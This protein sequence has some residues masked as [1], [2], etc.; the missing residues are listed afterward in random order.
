MA[1]R[2]QTPSGILATIDENILYEKQLVAVDASETLTYSIHAGA[3]PSGLNLTTTGK[4]TG[5]PNEVS[6]RTEK[7]FVV[8]ATSNARIAD[9][10]FTLFVE[11]SDAPTWVTDAGTL[12]IVYDGQFV[13]I[14]LQA[15]D[16]D[17]ADSSAINYEI[18][19]G[20]LPDSL[21]LDA[22]TGKI[23]GVIDSI[24]DESF[25]SAQLGF[26]AVAFDE[27][28]PFDLVLSRGSIDR[29]FEFTVRVT[30]GITHTDRKF[31]L[32]VRGI[33]Q[34]STDNSVLTADT[35]TV[36]ADQSDRTAVYFTQ[37]GVI[38]TLKS[39][40]YHIVKLSTI[41]PDAAG[42]LDGDTTVTYTIIAG[43]LPPG[44]S[45]DPETGTISGIVPLSLTSFTDYTFTVRASKV[46]TIFADVTTDQELIIRVTGN[47][48]ETLTW[49]VPQKEL[50]I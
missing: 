12:D 41:D 13:D 45:I 50:I 30:D 4:I 36:S 42:G 33:E 21:S 43:A 3:L 14:Q 15:T 39:N 2:W 26:D 19:D 35:S 37:S 25:D 44:T 49:T 9:R 18:I 31:A 17:T 5:Y 32:D 46:S 22:I 40:N 6:I 1:I 38:A 23:T 24:A 34:F 8:R 7:T 20:A 16:T 28:Q 27:T 11:G 10:T 48:Y 47:A 29:L